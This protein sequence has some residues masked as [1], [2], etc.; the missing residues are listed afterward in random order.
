MSGAFLVQ[1]GEGRREARAAAADDGKVDPF[2]A[3]VTCDAANVGVGEDQR[4]PIDRALVERGLRLAAEGAQ[5]V[6]IHAAG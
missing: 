6:A 5:R 4:Q 2:A 3:F 1:P